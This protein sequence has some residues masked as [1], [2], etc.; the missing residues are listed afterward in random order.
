MVTLRNLAI[1]L[2]NL[3]R[4]NSCSTHAG[5]KATG[6]TDEMVRVDL[7]KG[8]DNSHETLEMW[9]RSMRLFFKYFQI[10]CALVVLL[11]GSGGMAHVC[12]DLACASHT[13]EE[14]SAESDSQDCPADHCTHTCSC[15]DL[16]CDEPARFFVEVAPSN[17]FSLQNEACL[18]GPCRKIDHPPQLS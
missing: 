15:L 13:A 18:D 16:I 17:V 9:K 4:S 8:I 6:K 12:V 10:V 1:G 5:R 14:H 2:Y 7:G 11:M 3:P